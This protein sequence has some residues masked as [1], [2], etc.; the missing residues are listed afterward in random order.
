MVSLLY[1]P[2]GR[3]PRE[4]HIPLEKLLPLLSVTGA[5]FT[6]YVQPASA[7]CACEASCWPC[8][9]CIAM[10]SNQKSDRFPFAGNPRE[11]AGRLDRCRKTG[12]PPYREPFSFERL[13]PSL[14]DPNLP[15][16]RSP[17][18]NR[19]LSLS[20]T[21]YLITLHIT[22]RARSLPQRSRQK[23]TR[24]QVNISHHLS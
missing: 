24:M 16:A 11:R 18:R 6:Q 7:C 8:R 5:A 12:K 20:E 1:A 13:L 3:A 15:L 23:A 19:S 14:S 10:G 22:L 2:S 21:H 17:P 9:S 4:R